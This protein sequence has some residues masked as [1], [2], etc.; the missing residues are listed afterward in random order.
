MCMG[1]AASTNTGDACWES[2][3]LPTRCNSPRFHVEGLDC[4]MTRDNIYVDS[5]VGSVR[6]CG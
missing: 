1:R 4:R 5:G 6:L 2:E 3:H